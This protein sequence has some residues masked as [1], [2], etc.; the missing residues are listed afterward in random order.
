MD[1]WLRVELPGLIDLDRIPKTS[2]DLSE[3]QST[4]WRNALDRDRLLS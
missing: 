2:V 4:E 1:R 3:R